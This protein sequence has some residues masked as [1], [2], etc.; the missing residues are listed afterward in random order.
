MAPLLALTGL[1]IS[2]LTRRH[3]ISG[4]TAKAG[5]TEATADRIAC[6]HGLHPLL[7]WPDWGTH[8]P[9]PTPPTRTCADEKCGATFTPEHPLRKYCNRSCQRRAN[10]RR[11]KRNRARTDPA[12]RAQLAEAVRAYRDDI[13]RDAVNAAERRRYHRDAEA[14]RT[15]RRERYRRD[16]NKGSS[17]PPAHHP[18]MQ[19]TAA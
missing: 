2:Q 11:W 8:T 16:K 7:V 10:Q 6:A 1:N 5:L 19:E 9:A 15:A 3:S 4:A 17:Q 18:T 14:R 13:G 12:Y